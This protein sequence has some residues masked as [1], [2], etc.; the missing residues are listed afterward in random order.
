[1]KNSP[2]PK[3]HAPQSS[4]GP[5]PPPFLGPP[6]S[7]GGVGAPP[8]FPLPP[9]PPREGRPEKNFVNFFFA[10]GGFTL[11]NTLSMAYKRA[12]FGAS[13]AR[14]RYRSNQMRYRS[15]GS[16]R[17]STRKISQLASR[18]R[19]RPSNRRTGGYVGLELKFLDNGYVLPLKIPTTSIT[20]GLT[21]NNIGNI[22]ADPAVAIGAGGPVPLCLNAPLIGNSINN[23]DG[24][25]IHMKSIHIQGCVWG[26]NLA[27][28]GIAGGMQQMIVVVALVLD[29]QTNASQN[30]MSTVFVNPLGALN[31]STSTASLPGTANPLVNLQYRTRY[32][33]L[34]LKKLNLPCDL[35]TGD[36]NNFFS[37]VETRSFS[38]TH[39]F[40]GRGLVV[41]YI[42][43]TSSGTVTDIAD[44]SLHV[45]AWQTFDN[46]AFAG[47]QTL[48]ATLEYN[49]RLRYT[50]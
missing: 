10:R 11:I 38:I 45:V 9:P 40:K 22:A 13:S 43:A 21:L 33:I 7:P 49:A 2:S 47:G 29:T 44:H 27:T 31:G 24:R 35:F 28:R 48:S 32:R 8:A 12:R 36:G 6:T 14:Y 19:R 4:G 46:T 39:R 26:P 50:G 20:V 17:G 34:K 15:V 18:G 42:G 25:Q 30:D 41:N 3:R 37:S 1:L 23:R 16:A 5:P